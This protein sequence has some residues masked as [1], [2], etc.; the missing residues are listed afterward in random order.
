MSSLES[1]EI[2]DDVMECGHSN[3]L[4]KLIM[5]WKFCSNL[6]IHFS[7]TE[8]E[9][10]PISDTKLKRKFLLEHYLHFGSNQQLRTVRV[11]E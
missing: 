10:F 9:I 11:T 5:K 2:R 7:F 4:Q 6:A 3:L 8:R 1:I